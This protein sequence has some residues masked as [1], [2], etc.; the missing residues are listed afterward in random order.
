M[1]SSN[2]PTGNA[3]L[4]PPPPPSRSLLP[5]PADDIRRR[6]EEAIVGLI[7]VED[8]RRFDEREE[9]VDVGTA[10]EEL[11]VPPA[12]VTEPISAVSLTA[13]ISNAT[14]IFVR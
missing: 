7:A 11:V 6:D 10:A 13:A 3:T 8:L 2:T 4:P 1:E 5:S 14:G 12:P 9:V